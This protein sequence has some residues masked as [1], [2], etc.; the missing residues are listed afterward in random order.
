MDDEAAEASQRSHLSYCIACQYFVSI[1][2]M[3]MSVKKTLE[4]MHRSID[5]YEKDSGKLLNW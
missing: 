1:H 5:K 3:N 2:S 4:E